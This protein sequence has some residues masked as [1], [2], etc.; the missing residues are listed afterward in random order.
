MPP[1]VGWPRP[2]TPR[3]ISCGSIDPLGGTRPM[4]VRI[5][6]SCD[7]TWNRPARTGEPTNAAYMVR[8]VDP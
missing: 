6:V 7:G 8:A 5:I 3:V 2:A 4:P 1:T